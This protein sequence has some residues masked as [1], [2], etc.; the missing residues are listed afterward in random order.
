M[1]TVLRSMLAAA[2]L[3]ALAACGGGS[4]QPAP[5]PTETPRPSAFGAAAAIEM[6]PA[7]DLPGE[8]VNLPELYQDE[9]G[10]AHYGADSSEGPNTANHV[11]GDVDYEGAGNSNP[12]VGGPHWGS[13]ACG[14]DPATAPQNCGPAPWGIYRVPWAAETLVHNLEHGG[15]VV[16]YNTA[17]Q[18]IIDDLES[19]ARDLFPV[20]LTP[21]PDMEEE[22]IAIT[23]WGRIDKF[24]VSEY[25]RDRLEE[26]NDVH[27]C[28][29]NPEE[30]PDC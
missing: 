10:L 20:V 27:N 14:T 3:A 11:T 18:A 4:A 22:M 2:S 13:T 26:F 8:Y 12:P 19:F 23:S 17:D 28:R 21:Y 25:S 29:F 16:W 9:R 1:R 30:L 24:P 5:T 7:P 6:D 15:V